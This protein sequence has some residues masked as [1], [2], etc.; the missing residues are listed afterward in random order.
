MPAP[1]HGA[2]P[3]L[4]RCASFQAEP[5]SVE[6]A[7]RSLILRPSNGLGNQLLTAVSAVILACLTRRHLFVEDPP[8]AG[9]RSLAAPGAVSFLAAFGFCF[10]HSRNVTTSRIN[11]RGSS[12]S[13][14]DLRTDSLAA[15]LRLICGENTTSLAP[16]NPRSLLL[17]GESYFLKALLANPYLR[18]QTYRNIRRYAEPS[19]AVVSDF[20]GVC[21]TAELDRC[22][23][24]LFRFFFF[25]RAELQARLLS[26][27]ERPCALGVHMRSANTISTRG[28]ATGSR[29]FAY[30]IRQL[31]H[32]HLQPPL[33]LSAKPGSDQASDPA[34]AGTSAPIV[35]LAA[36]TDDAKDLLTSELASSS[37]PRSA[38]LVSLADMEAIQQGT[39]SNETSHA[40]DALLARSSLASWGAALPGY[41]RRQMLFAA[42]DLVAL[43]RCTMIIG[44][45]H[46]TFSYAAQALGT[47]P[48]ARVYDEEDVSKRHV[49]PSNNTT[50]H[51]FG[52]TQPAY[53]AWARYATL[54]RHLPRSCAAALKQ[55]AAPSLPLGDLRAARVFA[56]ETTLPPLAQ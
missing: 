53:H 47:R 15:H 36:G 12:V 52:F 32:T 22:F 51:V 1:Q 9:R 28:L 27:D 54:R 55:K 21:P 17:I 11:V 6:S 26:L 39:Q 45:R 13:V 30:C 46:S 4:R 43:S 8:S 42:A 16:N 40:A 31:L 18:R 49:G 10:E 38:T 50:C 33:Q 23:E 35:Y 48:Q 7:P 5:H 41:S 34:G 20:G 25:Y 56:T 37:P 19:N 29:R 2:P 14:L 24:T 3:W 44:T